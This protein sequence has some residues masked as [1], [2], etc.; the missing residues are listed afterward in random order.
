MITSLAAVVVQWLPISHPLCECGTSITLAAAT[1]RLQGAI[2]VP[3]VIAGGT[4]SLL[5]RQ[6]KGE[7]LLNCRSSIRSTSFA[8]MALRSTLACEYGRE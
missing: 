5:R 8:D 6:S 4:E 7:F 3:S 2:D 1:D